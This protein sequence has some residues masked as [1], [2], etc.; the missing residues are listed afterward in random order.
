VQ[1]TVTECVSGKSFRLA[2]YLRKYKITKTMQPF[3]GEGT[4]YDRW[5][6]KRIAT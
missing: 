5:T 4:P 3:I 2:Q 1:I 6:V